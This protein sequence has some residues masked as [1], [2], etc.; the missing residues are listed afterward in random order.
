MSKQITLEY[1]GMEGTG[2][3]ATE[4]KQ[5]AARK[6]EKAV[7]GS[8]TPEII[9]WRGQSV[10]I[11]RDAKMG[12]VYNAIDSPSAEFTQAR[13]WVSSILDGTYQTARDRAAFHLAQMMWTK[14]DG[15]SVPDF[16]TDER[17]RS[18]LA[19]C[20]R[21]YA[22]HAEAKDKGLDGQ[23]ASFYADVK[24]FGNAP[25][26]PFAGTPDRRAEIVSLAS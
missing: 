13:I 15:Q 23:E 20:F 12:W 8:Y 16:V 17:D 22:A 24:R 18:T 3:N 7:T 6:I 5:D 11:Y 10:L 21:H 9:S 26:V 1:F 14:D 19:D 25:F 4:A 2:R